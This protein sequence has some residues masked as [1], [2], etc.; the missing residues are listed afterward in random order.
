MQT[1]RREVSTPHAA[2]ETIRRTLVSRGVP[3]VLEPVGVCREGAKRSDSMTVIPW[4][5]GR[6]LL[7]DFICTDMVAPSN[8][9]LASRGPA[10]VAREETKRKKYSSLLPTYNFTPVCIETM[11]D[12]GDS[13]RDLVRTIGRRVQEST[14]YPRSTT[15]LVQR[16]ALDVQRGNVASVMATLPS[17]KDWSEVGLLPAL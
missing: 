8:R 6:S 17:T 13:V 9:T 15:F 2:N 7:W 5:C 12:W 11:G 16:L 4:E 3:S 14:G 10:S 1:E